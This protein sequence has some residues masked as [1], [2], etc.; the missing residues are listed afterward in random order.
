MKS[1]IDRQEMSK[2][3]NTPQQLL[4]VYVTFQNNAEADRIVDALLN[5]RLIACANVWS[6]RSQYIWHKKRIRSRAVAALLKTTKRQYK[7]L[8]QHILALHGDEVPC[9]VAWSLAQG[10]TDYL[11]WIHKSV[12]S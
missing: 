11:E 6:V 1:R 9:I 8:E 4:D 5:K 10:A 12:K 2:N 3:T 7:K